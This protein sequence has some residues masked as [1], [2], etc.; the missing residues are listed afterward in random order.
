[1][2]HGQIPSV[3]SII[4][5]VVRVTENIELAIDEELLRNKF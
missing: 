4:E 3:D 5:S 1:M 2:A